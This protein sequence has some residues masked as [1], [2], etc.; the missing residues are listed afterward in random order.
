MATEWY[1]PPADLGYDEDISEDSDSDTL[2]ETITAYV[3]SKGMKVK[4]GDTITLIEG[5]S[6]YRNEN[7]YMW[8]G[9]KVIYLDY[10]VDDYGS[11]PS[12]F[13]VSD[14][15]FAPDYWL[16]VIDHNGYFYL[17]KSIVERFEFVKEE[18]RIVC[19][20]DIGYTPYKVYTCYIDSTCSEDDFK[21]K[22]TAIKNILLKKKS[23][24]CSMT[25]YHKKEFQIVTF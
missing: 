15:E 8:D 11:V 14:T 25:S 13:V 16:H 3:K 20:I 24:L 7:V 9:T 10:E 1:I 23:I 5:R 19:T 4:R 12:Q 18:D 2:I 6:R 17:S 22:A 21:M